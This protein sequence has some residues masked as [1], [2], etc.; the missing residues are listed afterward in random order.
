MVGPRTQVKLVVNLGLELRSLDS[1]V[2]PCT[3][4]IHEGYAPLGN[5]YY[6]GTDEKAHA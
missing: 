5:F 1:K 4:K 2:E 3:S 6:A